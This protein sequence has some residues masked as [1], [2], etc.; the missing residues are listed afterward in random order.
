MKRNTGSVLLKACPRT[1]FYT[2]YEGR[3]NYFSGGTVAEW[4]TDNRL[5]QISLKGKECPD[6]GNERGE[7]EYTIYVRFFDRSIEKEIENYI[8]EKESRNNN[9][10]EEQ[11][12]KS[13]NA[14]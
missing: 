2:D 5:L 12:Q 7:Y 3:K 6:Y 8:N 4:K 1:T 14:L 9:R 10:I 11:R 13:V